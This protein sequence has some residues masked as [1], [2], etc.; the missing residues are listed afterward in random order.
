MV[1]IT[2]QSNKDE[3]IST[4]VE[5]IDDQSDVIKELQH[6]QRILFIIAGLLLVL[7]F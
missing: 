7:Q 2:P 1:D 5:L 6:Q 4:A 3:I